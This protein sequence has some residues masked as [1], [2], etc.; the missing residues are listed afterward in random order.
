M[1]AEIEILPKISRKFYSKGLKRIF[2][3]KKLS[4]IL[5][6]RRK[7]RDPAAPDK[8]RSFDQQSKN[9]PVGV[10]TESNSRL[11][12]RQFAYESK[13]MSTNESIDSL[14]ATI[15][16][17]HPRRVADSVAKD[18]RASRTKTQGSSKN[19]NSPKAVRLNSSVRPSKL[20]NLGETVVVGRMDE[21]GGIPFDPRMSKRHFSVEVT[22][23]GVFVE[24]LQSTNGTWLNGKRIQRASL[25]HGDK[26]TSGMTIF[27]VEWIEAS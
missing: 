7:N 20:V 6:N 15:A 1:Y 16:D 8:N 18:K 24:D 25:F 21:Q 26:I 27:E 14:P 4:A 11:A 13:V 22:P 23:A 10:L 19:G 17:Y 5:Q 9:Q 12:F 3:K 2:L